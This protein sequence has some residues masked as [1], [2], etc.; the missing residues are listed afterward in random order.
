[1]AMIVRI[2]EVTATAI[3]TVMLYHAEEPLKTVMAALTVPFDRPLPRI[4]DAQTA[5][6][7]K[8]GRQGKKT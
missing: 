7:R 4:V 1:M 3:A 5:S 2:K 8:H 6:R